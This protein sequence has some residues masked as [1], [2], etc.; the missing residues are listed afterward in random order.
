MRA[1]LFLTALMLFL[2]RGH[3]AHAEGLVQLTFQGEIGLRGGAP[4]EVEL[5]IWDGASVREFALNVHLGERTRA[6]DL[7]A[8]LAARLRRV[9]AKVDFTDEGA[10][11][12]GVSHLFIDSVTHANLRL[13]HG[14]WGA[15][16]LCDA[17]PRSVRFQPP[18][19]AKEGAEIHVA[20]TT[21]QPHNR[22]LERVEISLEVDELTT[23]AQIS[24]QLASVSISK[25]WVA[26]RP[27]P[28]RWAASRTSDGATITGCSIELLSP[29]AD[30]RVEVQLEVP[31]VDSAVER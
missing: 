11:A 22:H 16:T 5:G 26:D 19:I 3:A 18:E 14:L 1:M 31:R 13:G 17:A 30:W 6:H 8:L 20:A 29:G 28:D 12:Q 24:E 21:F 25:G 15:V 9:G 23:S 10:A 27:A 4:V 2:A 7:A